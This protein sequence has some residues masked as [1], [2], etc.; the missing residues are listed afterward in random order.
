[1]TIEIA[2]KFNPKTILGID[3]DGGLIKTAKKN[4]IRVVP[5]PTG[6]TQ[7]SIKFPKSFAKVYGPIAVHDD[8]ESNCNFPNNIRFKQVPHLS[9]ITVDQ[10]IFL[11]YRRIMYQLMMLL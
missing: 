4:V 6:S 10:I 8:V 7:G 5:L 3:I 11:N 2:R 1:M 9:V